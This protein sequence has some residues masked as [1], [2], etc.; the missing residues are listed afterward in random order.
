MLEGACLE[1]VAENCDRRAPV[2]VSGTRQPCV[3]FHDVTPRD[4]HARR[5]STDNSQAERPAR[6]GPLKPGVRRPTT[7]DPVFCLEP[8]DAP[9]VFGVVRDERH[10]QRQGMSRHEG[11]ERADGLAAASQ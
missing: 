3:V 8:H 7:S 4:P 5:L 2:V 1:T 6:A 10:A 11:V 9:E